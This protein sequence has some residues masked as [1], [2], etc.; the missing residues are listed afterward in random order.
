MIEE[1]F[2]LDRLSSA[3]IHRQIY[4]RVRAGIA[5]GHLRPG[6]RLPSARGLASQLGTARGT[7]D[8]AYAELAGEGWIVARGP[9]GTIVAP[10][11]P[12][13]IANQTLTIAAPGAEPSAAI[14]PEA[15]PRPF[16][17]GL[18]ALDAFPRKLWAR[19]AAREARMISVTGLSYPHPAGY[20]ALR[21]AVAAYLLMSRG[22]ACRP[23]QV[24]I[25]VGYQGALGLVVRALLQH[26][27]QVWFEDPGYHLAR[28]ALIDAGA[29]LVPIPVDGEGLCVEQGLASAPDARLAVVTP[30]HQC[31]LGVAL[32]LP[33]RVA[34]LA[35]AARKK[36]WIIEDDYDGEFHYVGR[37]LPAL[38]SLDGNDVVL[39]AGS[40]SKVLFPALRLGY[41]V[42]PDRLVDRFATAARTFLNGNP[43]LEQAI[44]AR[45]M[46]EG[47]FARHLK[48]M[49]ALY[50]ARRQAFADALAQEFGKR[51]E[52]RLG[53]GGMHLI[54][55]VDS[56]V[57]DIKLAAW[58]QAEGLA[59]TALSG[60]T[61][62]RPCDR[63]LL[64]GFT[65]IA[66]ADAMA[67]CRRLAQVLGKH[68]RPSKNV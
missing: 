7:V 2:R 12:S 42:V 39:Y 30:A 40:F 5:A 18:P 11:A 27:D 1:L 61:L 37:P 43:A 29:S 31:P 48:R 57:D 41:L 45:F 34:L 24:F 17:M 23:R 14:A 59:V 64:L 25:S 46:T 15:G 4:D 36:A 20:A 16:Q 53:A 13:T 52:I 21:E 32:S 44:V 68:W 9:A 26:G 19:L 54:A 35:W 28:E 66:E 10:Q 47:H 60:L 50:A 8:A 33:R 51:L 55:A 3:P 63:G 56:G 38:K 67:A 65:N 22:I 62:A 58:A 49:R 6:E